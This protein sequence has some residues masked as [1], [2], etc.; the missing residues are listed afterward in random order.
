MVIAPHPDDETLGCGGTLL[1]HKTNGDE[2]HW[3]IL[4]QISEDEGWS[5]KRVKSR[6]KEIE[7]VT[8]AYGF[9]SVHELDFK[10]KKLD[11]VPTSDL[12]ERIGAVINKIQPNTLYINNRCDIHTDHQI[13][14]KAVISCTKNF[15]YPFINR[16]YMYETLSETEFSPPLPGYAFQPNMFVDISEKFEQKLKIM[17]FY[18]GEILEDPYPRS[19]KSLE[20]L[21]RYRGSRIGVKYAE[22]FMLIFEAWKS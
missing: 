21:A 16:V 1:K 19:L 17:Q 4:T 9:N 3:L 2:I 18:D 15:R 6:P 13:A 20:F 8:E 7:M 10:A 14:F 22:A 11:T 12:V 5:K